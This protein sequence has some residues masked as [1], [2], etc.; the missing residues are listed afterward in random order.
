[1]L[2]KDKVAL[3]TGGG[4][5]IGRAIV[6]RFLEEG[7]KVVTIDMDEVGLAETITEAEKAGGKV[8]TI[9]ANVTVREDVQNVVS[10]IFS[11]LHNQV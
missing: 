1:M 6:L 3:I 9:K 11:L 5:G 4:N 2:L 7:A 10:A 8:T